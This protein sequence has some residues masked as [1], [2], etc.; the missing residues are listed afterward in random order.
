MHPQK[1]FISCLLGIKRGTKKADAKYIMP[2]LA[3]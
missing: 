2:N 3:K 1:L